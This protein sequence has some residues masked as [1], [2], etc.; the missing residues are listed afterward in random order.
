MINKS[1][2]K[3]RKLER[4]I[5]QTHERAIKLI[6]QGIIRCVLRSQENEINWQGMDT[7]WLLAESMAGQAIEDV[8][9]ILPKG[10]ILDRALG[11]PFYRHDFIKDAESNE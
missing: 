2:I 1:R 4:D 10:D 7:V 6:K 5:E 11:I 9:I 8:R 3:R